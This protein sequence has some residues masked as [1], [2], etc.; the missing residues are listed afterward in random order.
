MKI[1]TIGDV[2][3]SDFWK[4]HVEENKDRV[5]CV[6]FMGDYF[7]SH[8]ITDHKTIFKNFKEILESKDTFEK[9]VVMLIGNHDFHYSSFCYGRYSGYDTNTYIVAH[10]LVDELIHHGELQLC[11]VVDNFIFSHAGV[12]SVWFYD[13]VSRKTKPV[14]GYLQPHG[15][16][17]QIVKHKKESINELQQLFV[18]SPRIV[19]FVDDYRTRSAYG[20]DPHQ[21]PIWIRPSSLLKYPYDGDYHQVVGHTA[22]NFQNIDINYNEMANGKNLYCV[23][24]HQ[25]E[26]FIIDTESGDSE[27]LR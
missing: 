8:D 12:S 4:R 16:S 10:E 25:R 26:A 23:D 19:N 7:D 24:S 22:F 21:T 2:H 27:I 18:D 9:P 3:G 15:D 6:V 17:P 1:L 20:D 13:H 14:K 5:D 11:H